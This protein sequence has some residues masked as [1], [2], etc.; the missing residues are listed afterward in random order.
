[1]RQLSSIEA[2]KIAL[3]PV[4]TISSGDAVSKIGESFHDVSEA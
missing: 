3:G 2:A 4:L 1:L